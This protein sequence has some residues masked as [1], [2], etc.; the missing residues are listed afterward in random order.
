MPPN[1][2]AQV[3]IVDDNPAKLLSLETTLA[4]SG[5]NL[6]T[7]AS[8]REAL[9][10]LLTQDVAVI[11]LDVNM[12][13]LGGFETAALIR[14]HCRSAH[15]P[16]IFISAISPPESYATTGYL[17]GAVDYIFLQE[18]LRMVTSYVQKRKEYMMSQTHMAIP[19][20]ILVVDDN[21]GDVQLIIEA[22]HDV[23]LSNHLH[24]AGDGVEAL[25]FLRR[26]A[27]HQGAP[28]PDLILLDLN[29]PKKDGRAVLAEIKADPELGRIPV[30]ILTTSRQEVD[31]L[32]AYQ[33]KANCYITKPVDFAQFITVIQAIDNFWFS[34]V[35]LPTQQT[36]LPE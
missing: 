5:Y 25:A 30:V 29:L 35:T 33:L 11:L 16:I 4:N 3:L 13:G 12:P 34:V 18:P 36:D 22:F 31:V 32:R 24:S 15:I 6:V 17:L 9:R 23:K 2:Q 27:P 7:A 28:R 21:P 14:K 1:R 20:E 10:Y 8:G 26:E 19:I